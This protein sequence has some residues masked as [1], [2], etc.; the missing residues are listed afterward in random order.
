MANRAR[1][2][3]GAEFRLGN[4]ETNETFTKVAMV[5]DIR[6]ILPERLVM[7]DATTQDTPEFAQEKKPI[8]VEVGQI[9]VDVYWDPEDSTHDEVEGLRADQEER[10]ERNFQI[11]IPKSPKRI[12]FAG[13]VVAM[14]PSMPL[15]GLMEATITI[16]PTGPVKI[17][18]GN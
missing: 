6:N 3:R 2:G 5:R 7:V 18:T 10:V 11:K 13:Y 14:S 12:D 4:G 9:E 8:D 17:V 16:D 1:A 15:K